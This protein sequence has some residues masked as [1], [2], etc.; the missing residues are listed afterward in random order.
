MTSLNSSLT[1]KSGTILIN[2]QYPFGT[3]S[4]ITWTQSGTSS[5]YKAGTYT[6]TVPSGY[7]FLFAYFNIAWTGSNASPTAIIRN[8]LIF[9]TSETLE[10]YVLEEGATPNLDVLQAKCFFVKS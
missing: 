7:T 5:K 1:N 8:P 6:I 2:T 10:C 9:N 4:S 3:A